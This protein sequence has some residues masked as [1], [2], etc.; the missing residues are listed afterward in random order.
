M[1]KLGKFAAA[2]AAVVCAFGTV[3]VRAGEVTWEGASGGDWSVGENWST[4]EVPTAN[5]DVFL[6]KNANV[7]APAGVAAKSITLTDATLK[8]GSSDARTEFTANVVGSLTLNGASKLYV[9]AKTF[10]DLSV[11]ADYAMACAA[12]WA[13]ASVVEI[14]GAFAVNDTSVVYPDND[15]LTGVPVLFK[16]KDFALASG[17]KVCAN[18]LGWGI[19]SFTGTAPANT[20]VDGGGYTYAFSCGNGYSGGAGYGG[21]GGGTTKGTAP[22][23][24]EYAPFLPGAPAGNYGSP[25]ARGGGSVC[26]FATGDMQIEGKVTACGGNGNSNMYSGSTGG[27]IWLGTKTLSL[28][29]AAAID[30]SGGTYSGGYNSQGSGGRIS[31][32]CGLTESD[33]AQLAAGTDPNTFGLSAENLTLANF[34]ALG[35]ANSGGVRAA[36]STGT[37][38]IVAK[39]TVSQPVVVTATPVEY[40]KGNP[41]LSPAYGLHAFE[42]NDLPDFVAPEGTS[43]AVFQGLRRLVNAGH[44]DTD[45]AA[46]RTVTWKWA[47]EEC[48][49]R[50]VPCGNGKIT[51]ND[52]DYTSEQAM[53]ITSGTELTLTATPDAGAEFK[54]WAGDFPGMST[55]ATTFSVTVDKA[56]TLN[57][58]FT[59]VVPETKSYVG[60]DGGFW[61]FPE[62]WQPEGVPSLKDDVVLNGK[63]V[64][65]NGLALANSLSQTGGTL[66]I[67]GKTTTVEKQAV[68]AEYVPWTGLFVVG[69]VSLSGAAFSLGAVHPSPLCFGAV[70]GGNLSV[71]GASK[72]AFYA[73]ES[74]E[75]GIASLWTNTV[76]VVI[77]GD[78]AVS[79]TSTVY[80]EVDGLTGTPV[81]FEVGGDVS[82][83][84]QAKICADGRGYHWY[85][86]D[87][88]N[89]DTRPNAHVEGKYYTFSPGWGSS[90]TVGG[91]YGIAGETDTAK[92][93]PFGYKYAPYLSGGVSGAQERIGRAGGQVWIEAK[94]TFTLDGKVTANA[95]EG[96]STRS[97]S[98]GGGIWLAAKKLVCGDSAALSANGS[99]CPVYYTTGP[100]TGGRIS[101]AIAVSADALDALAHGE[102]PEGL[103]YSDAISAC[104]AT[105]LGGKR[106]DAAGVYYSPAGTLTTVL[107]E[108]SEYD[109]VTMSVPVAVEAENL[110][111]GTSKVQ[112]GSTW[113]LTVGSTGFDPVQPDIVR[114][115]CA[116]WVVSNVTEEVARGETAAASFTVGK[117]PFTITWHWKDRET[118]TRVVPND[119]ELG[120]VSVNGGAATPTADVWTADT[121]VV[122][123]TAVANAGAEFLYWTGDVPAES[124]TKATLTIDA[125]VPFGLKP[126][127]RKIAEPT[128][129]VWQVAD[130]K[131]GNWED[132]ANWMPTNVPGPADTVTIA[133]GICF[134]SNY[135]SC[136]ALNLSGNGALKVGVASNAPF[137]DVALIVAGD[138]TLTNSA[139]LTVND[140]RG[141]FVHQACVTI[142]GDLTL[143]GDSTFAVGAGS[144]NGVSRTMATGSCP[145]TVGGRLTVAG[146]AKVTAKGDPWTGGSVVFRVGEFAVMSNATVSAVGGGYM[147]MTGTGLSPTSFAPGRGGN[148]SVGGGYGGR[149][150]GLDS[151]SGLT[152]GF[153]LAPVHPGSHMG[154]Y[155]LGY[156]YRGG[157]LI[158]VHA[159]GDMTL[160]GLFDADCYS[161]TY[162]NSSGGGIW[163]TAGGRI[164]VGEKAVFRAR[165]GTGATTGIGGGGRI[166][167]CQFISPAQADRMALDGEYHGVGKA[168]KHVFGRDEFRAVFGLPETAVDLSD[169]KNNEAEPYGGSFTYIDGTPS[170]LMLI[171]K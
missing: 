120:G 164:K 128:N 25:V 131:S 90:Y 166:S 100:G 117:G 17:A 89:P 7:V 4:G 141:S 64:F 38:T 102:E 23:G 114:Y 139:N 125:K 68:A 170:G 29:A 37:I 47:N 152:Y 150:Q 96:S 160:N 92:R 99:G 135:A 62:N 15:P 66:A 43:P 16:T 86:K 58:L 142:G 27:G 132:A 116:G 149:G 2:C 32:A 147:L 113:A 126:V 122:T 74:A 60:S 88:D 30:V 110:V 18:E 155:R 169:G 11:F 14:G 71:S 106:S 87:Q 69:D 51:M 91:A 34:T 56:M 70:I 168:A 108:V 171:V 45:G 76:K 130:K 112:V 167:V 146:K 153:A 65:C 82:V 46:I 41:A 127:F 10:A 118:L 95:T 97:G 148:Y 123:L 21:K 54:F 158:R 107:G 3:T 84:A 42:A 98:S 50:I 63:K 78:F 55:D 31:L 111:Y 67:G 115:T 136:A 143:D 33:F 85:D 104:T 109:L 52:V 157:G 151:S 138:V 12:I 161:R 19:H 145:V 163:L 44:D 154:D 6:N 61:H 8:I 105:A 121:G 24:F 129:Y 53:W 1:N 124:A 49:V 75:T 159:A 26:V 59:G 73:S 80:V 20:R 5:D 48:L 40:E 81:K 165:G 79:D 35:G 39:K 144:T 101:V 103:T 9:Y 162:N 83:G 137:K 119:P 133:S 93:R 134:A 72:A 94:G 140:E 22:Y 28:G 57:A 13:N 36:N 156:D 77:S